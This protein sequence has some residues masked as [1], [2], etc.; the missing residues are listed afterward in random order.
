MK[1]AVLN[2]EIEIIPKRFDKTYFQWIDNLKDWCISRQIWWG[3]RLPV[4]YCKECAE[5]NISS[6][7]PIKCSKCNSLNIVQ[8]EDTL[9]TWFSSALWPFATMGWPNE[10]AEDYKTYYP[11]SVLETGYDILFFWVARM[12]MLGKYITKKSP[13]KKV[14]LHGLVCDQTGQKMSKSKGNGIDPDTVIKEY[15]ADAIR[16]SLIIGTTPGNNINIYNEKISGYRN[17]INKLW[18]IA[19]FII[20]YNKIFEEIKPEDLENLKNPK[21]ILLE[22]ELNLT[23][24]W[25]LSRINNVI[26]NVTNKLDTYRI[27]EAGEILYDFIWRD[28]ADWYVEIFKIKEYN[29]QAWVLRYVFI[30]ILKLLHPFSPFI[31]EY[32]WSLIFDDKDVNNYLI[33]SDW[34]TVN[35]KLHNN[36][37]I[38]ESFETIKNIISSVRN[39]RSEHNVD[40]RVKLNSIILEHDNIKLISDNAKIIKFLSGIETIKISKEIPTE[41]NFIKFISSEFEIYIEISKHELNELNKKK[42]KEIKILEN[43]I[44]AIEKKLNDKTFLEKAPKEIV[45][46]E[47]EKYKNFK[48]KL[49][50]LKS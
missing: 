17:F 36:K 33:N 13:F 14:Y 28:F 30:N 24:K 27:G 44:S 25:I 29:C 5:I 21:N 3:Q 39:V 11:N 38:S 7:K 37:N 9:D 41:D 26:E 46:K 32:L 12:I 1:E 16:L 19:R 2:G 43:S 6:H 40:K 10:D 18:N 4:Y 15:G 34:P 8:D 49:K 45:E 35:I 47:Q 48:D 20:D 50:K 42:D 23:D 31:T 22:S